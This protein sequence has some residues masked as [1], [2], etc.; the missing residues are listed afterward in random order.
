M[1]FLTFPFTPDNGG[2]FRVAAEAAV[3][4]VTQCQPYEMPGDKYDAWREVILNFAP[5]NMLGG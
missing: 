4:A 3:R 1:C 5:R 2:N